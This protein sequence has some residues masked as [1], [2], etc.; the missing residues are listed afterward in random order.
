MRFG[1]SVCRV[2]LALTCVAAV[3][4][5]GCGSDEATHTAG[6]AMAPT[7]TAK[8]EVTIDE[9]RTEPD[10]GDVILYNPPLSAE[11]VM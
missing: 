9:S 10:V 4:A 8:A 3:A 5:V 2:G 1:L 6:G 11:N 7:I